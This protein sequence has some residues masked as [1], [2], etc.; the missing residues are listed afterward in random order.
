MSAENMYI[1]YED[2]LFEY[3]TMTERVYK[4]LWHTYQYT[5]QFSAAI[6]ALYE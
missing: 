4:D 1:R 6:R 3:P 2:I 5:I